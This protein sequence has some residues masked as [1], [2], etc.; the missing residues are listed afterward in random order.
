MNNK[1]KTILIA[2]DDE[3]DITL[4]NIAL[5][6]SGL[7]GQVVIAR[8][9]EEAMDFL[10]CKGKFE[11]N[12]CPV[13]SLVLLDLKL[14]KVSGLEILRQIRGND[15]LKSVPV[16]IFTSSS[17]EKDRRECLAR[18]ADDFVIKPINFKAF[19]GAID[20]IMKNYLT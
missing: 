19:S 12:S 11:S 9:G 20:K 3:G 2:E 16:V 6:K 14:P 13:P 1:N 8:E 10:R 7:A 5:R 18:G 4:I 15:R 17:D